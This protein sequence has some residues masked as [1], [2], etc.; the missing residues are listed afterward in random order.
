MRGGALYRVADPSWDDPLDVEYCTR[1]GGRWN[2]AGSFGVHYLNATPANTPSISTAVTLTKRLIF[3]PTTSH[4]PP[5]TI[6]YPS[7]STKGTDD[8]YG[9]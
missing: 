9:G 1:S 6:G 3:I 8:A 2:P 5:S 4:K 7:N